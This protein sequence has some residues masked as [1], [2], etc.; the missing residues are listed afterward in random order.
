[1]LLLENR[2]ISALK[3]LVINII[4]IYLLQHNNYL[5]WEVFDECNKKIIFLS[6]P[7]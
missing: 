5:S 1:M 2:L 3:I 6:T 4:G 7:F